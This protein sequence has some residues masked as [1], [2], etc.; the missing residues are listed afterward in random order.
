[1]E[2]LNIYIGPFETVARVG[3]IAYK[4]NQPIEFSI[5][6]DVCHESIISISHV[7]KIMK[8]LILRERTSDACQP[9]QDVQVDEKFLFTGKPMCVEGDQ[10]CKRLRMKQVPIVKVKQDS[11]TRSEI[12]LGIGERVLFKFMQLFS[13]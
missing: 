7:Y 4:S 2:S 9:I 10:Q 5:L 3:T 8:E 1:M 13:R 11:P 12:Y 6:H